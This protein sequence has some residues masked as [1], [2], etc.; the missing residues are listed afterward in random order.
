MTSWREGEKVRNVYLFQFPS[1]RD[2]PCDMPCDPLIPHWPGRFLT[3]A[4][5]SSLLIGICLV[6]FAYFALAVYFLFFQFPSHR[7]MPCDKVSS[8]GPGRP[9]NKSFQF[10]SHRDMPCDQIEIAKNSAKDIFFQFP[11]HR[12]MPCDFTNLAFIS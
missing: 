8:T 6:T 11:S 10:P 1:H 7:D 2:M 3:T 4:S 9:A 12:D 5:F